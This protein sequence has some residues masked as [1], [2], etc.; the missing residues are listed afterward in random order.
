MTTRINST[1]PHI[2]LDDQGRAWI[3]AT[4]VKVIEV[5]LDTIADGL[6][7]AEIRDEHYGR[8]S[9][10]QIHAA[11]AWYYDHQ[12][13]CDAEIR[14]QVEEVDRAREANRDSPIHQK[15]RAM[16]RIV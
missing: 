16:G 5:V 4:N 14:R 13:E 12:A 2:V 8:L 7:P 11:L 3:D 9:L 1:M 6:S 10:A 15:L